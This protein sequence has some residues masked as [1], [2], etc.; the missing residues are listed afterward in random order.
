[1]RIALFSDIHGNRHALEAVLRD[2]EEQRPDRVYCLGDL[3]GYGAFPDAVV[4]HPRRRV[5]HGHGQL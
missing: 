5:S 4:E 3:V 2:I 1:M